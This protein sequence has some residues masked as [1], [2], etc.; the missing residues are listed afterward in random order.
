MFISSDSFKFFELGFQVDVA[1][2]GADQLVIVRLVIAAAKVGR[3]VKDI[4]RG[5]AVEIE[6]EISE[7]NLGKFLFQLGKVPA[8]GYFSALSV[9]ILSAVPRLKR[10]VSV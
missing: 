3:I 6:V 10:A 9:F 8:G 2:A 1:A 7:I 4:V 5:L